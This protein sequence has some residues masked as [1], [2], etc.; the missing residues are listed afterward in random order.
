MQ[1]EEFSKGLTVMEIAYKN[2][3]FEK[4]NHYKI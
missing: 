4:E 2:G 1:T 3:Y